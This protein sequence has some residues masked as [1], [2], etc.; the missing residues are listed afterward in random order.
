[1]FLNPPYGRELRFWTAKARSEFEL[2]IAKTVIAL[3]PART[4][5]G[6]WLNDIAW[7]ASIFFLTGRLS[8]GDGSRPAPFPSALIVRGLS[9][10]KAPLLKAT[11]LEA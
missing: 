7:K 2:G 8:F 9:L 5:T 11:I 6:C 4:D 10:E 1:V 3:V